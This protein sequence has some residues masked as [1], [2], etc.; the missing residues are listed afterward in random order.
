MVMQKLF[1][2]TC[3]SDYFRI[4]NELFFSSYSGE[5]SFK[6]RFQL[7]VFQLIFHIAHRRKGLGFGYYVEPE[8][9][10]GKNKSRSANVAN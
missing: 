10:D 3:V 5:N 6:V 8:I 4:R 1:L 7:N 2:Y 9:I